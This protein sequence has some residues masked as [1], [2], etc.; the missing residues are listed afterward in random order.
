MPEGNSFV[1]RL[2]GD[3]HVDAMRELAALFRRRNSTLLLIKGEEPRRWDL[4]GAEVRHQ[5]ADPAEV[6]RN[7]SRFSQGK[8]S[9]DAVGRY[10]TEDVA[11]AL[12]VADRP[13]ERVAIARAIVVKLS[14]DDVTLR[15]ILTRSQP[16]VRNKSPPFLLAVT[17]DHATRGRRASQHECAFRL[18]YVVFYRG[19]LHALEAADWLLREI[20]SAALRLNWGNMAL[21]HAVHD[22][23]DDAGEPKGFR[24]RDFAS[25]LDPAYQQPVNPVEKIWS[26][27]K[28]SLAN[29][30]ASTATTLT[31]AVKNRLKKMQYSHGP[32]EVYLTGTGLSPPAP[33]RPDRERLLVAY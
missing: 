2:P 13:K 4:H 25:L 24:E 6:S 28:R 10:L 27:M 3:G 15:L 5:A 9:Q 11:R 26:G 8:A 30:P 17:G 33:A 32:I 31:V 19:S 20:G 23:L 29:L 16:S 14:V 18:S 1:L 12:K 22:L 7:H 21:Q